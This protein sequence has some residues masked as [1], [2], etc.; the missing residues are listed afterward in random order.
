MDSI[1]AVAGPLCATALLGI[2][3]MRGVLLWTAAP[4]LAAAL[5]FAALAPSS[6]GEKNQRALGF[7][8]SLRDLPKTFWRLAAASRPRHRRF[9]SHFI[10]S[11]RLANS[12]AA[13]QA[14]AAPQ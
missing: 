8:S 14:Q 6:K 1:G 13:R 10:N 11:P 7:L 5:A 2:L 12:H 3:G 4:G 9:R